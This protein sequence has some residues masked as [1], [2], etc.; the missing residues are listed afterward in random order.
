[1][2]LTFY[3]LCYSLLQTSINPVFGQTS[4]DKDQRQKQDSLFQKQVIEQVVVTGQIK[5]TSL[6]N[7]IYAVRT[8]NRDD[9]IRRATSDITTLL[10]TQLGIRFNNDLV[11]GESD[12]ELM[13]MSGQNVKILLDGIPLIDR[14]STKQSLS[15][16]DINTIERI[17]LVE[18]PVSVIYG[19]DALAGVIN[20]ITRD[21]ST[22]KSQWNLEV[23]LLEETVNTEYNPAY[24]EGR[25]N[26]HANLIYSKNNWYGNM[27]ASR[28]TFGGYQGNLSG[29]ALAWQPK[30]QY[31]ASGK[32]GY[33]HNNL[34]V[35]YN[36]S[37][38]DEDI[39]TP[40]N[41]LPN[42]RYID[43]NYLTN[44]YNH[45]VQADWQWKEKWNFVSSFT[46]QN[47]R[48]AT[49]T[50]IHDFEKGTMELSTG[51]GEQDV[52]TFYQSFGKITGHYKWSNRLDLLSGVDI[53]YDR[54]SGARIQERSEIW[55]LAAFI[56][57][58]YRPISWLMIR[59]GLRFIHNSIYDAPPVIPSINA[60]LLLNEHFDLR[61]SYARGFRAPS[62]REL[63]FNFFD[64]NHQIEGNKDLKAEHSNSY[65]LN[66][67]FEKAFHSQAFLRTSFGSYYNQFNNLVTMS[68]KPGD[69]RVNT[70]L[71]L[72]HYKTTGFNLANTFSYKH[73]KIDLGLGYIGRYN[74]QKA[75]NQELK[76]FLWTPELNAG[77][78]QEIP[79]W[80]T[81]ISVFYKYNG[82]RPGYETIQTN[83]GVEARQ[84]SL[85]SFQQLDLSVNKTLFK[86]LNLQAGIR[87]LTNTENI[88][89]T[90]TVGSGAHSSS[91]SSV[92]ISYGRSYFF[93]LLY[94]LNK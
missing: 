11:L 10:N 36:F 83:T 81:N 49:V 37:L 29:R 42:N 5:P 45:M 48:R 60:K 90:A 53:D 12:I 68:M 44:R 87:N 14:G 32:I 70:Y 71:N 7:S 50:N 38:L 31:L 6:K 64:S 13:G 67:N 84:T 35:F 24:A 43:K 27:T 41:I 26:L 8:I 30:D 20:I 88:E 39:Y 86:G 91:V 46:Q 59:P 58:D 47:Y 54:G 80:A 40:G 65:H 66:L 73:L 3:I 69:N 9:I 79:R 76:Q 92:P 21:A 74:M 25:H 28:N 77:I 94:N 1:M 2:R 15:Q 82:K 55:D 62:L 85:A 78:S 89:N 33:N 56:T 52:S 4:L 17:E 16:I 18:G 19:T 63:Y 34:H 72:A 93:G 57:A 75:I 51:A 22:L 23:R 61:L